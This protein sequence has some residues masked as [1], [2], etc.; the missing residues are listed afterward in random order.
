VAVLILTSALRLR[1]RY[2]DDGLQAVRDAIRDLEAVLADSAGGARAVFPDEGAS[3]HAGP[4]WMDLGSGGAVRYAIDR[5]RLDDEDTLVIIGGDEVVPFCRLDNPVRDR[6]LDPD[7]AVL[8]DNP[9]GIPRRSALLSSS[10]GLLTPPL[11]V[12]RIPDDDP[13][14]LESFLERIRGAEK[15]AR[16]PDDGTFALANLSWERRAQKVLDGSPSVVR[17]TPGW[18]GEDPEWDGNRASILYFKLHGFQAHARWQGFDSRAGCFVDGLRPAQVTPSAATGRLVFAANCYGALV[19]KRSPR[20]SIALAFLESGARAVVGAT[21]LAFGSYFDGG[22]LDLSDVLARSFLRYVRQGEA[23]GRAL[24]RARI[25]FVESAD[26]H[27]MTTF[28]QKTALQ[29]VVLGN[30]LATL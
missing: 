22:A 17:A 10:K 3:V 20:T 26:R 5:F 18:N 14:R 28:A 21:S 11:A 27:G 30:P 24:A 4:G 1:A 12:G 19:A 9:Y 15:A 25:E 2:G 8:S 13:P 23:V 29:Y 6:S 7:S 16:A